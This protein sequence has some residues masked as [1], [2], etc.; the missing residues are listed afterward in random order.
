VRLTR[1]H[2][3]AAGG[4]RFG[5][6]DTTADNKRDVYYYYTEGLLT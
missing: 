2:L 1:G 5:D 6:N 4:F 3:K